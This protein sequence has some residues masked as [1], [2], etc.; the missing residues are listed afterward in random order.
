MVN[1]DECLVEKKFCDSSCINIL[2]KDPDSPATVFTNTSSFVGVNAV[3]E[4][5]CE[6]KL[7]PDIKCLNGGTRVGDK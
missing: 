3:V 7:E 4:F 2:T 6:C 1:I 5:Q